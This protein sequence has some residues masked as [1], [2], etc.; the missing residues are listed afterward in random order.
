MARSGLLWAGAAG[1]WGTYFVPAQWA[2]EPA[3]VSNFPLALGIL[4][5]GLVLALAAGEP[6]GWARG[7]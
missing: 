1:S 4:G 7:P 6:P 3:Q 5:A 2:A